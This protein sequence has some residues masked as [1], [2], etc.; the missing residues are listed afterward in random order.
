MVLLVPLRYMKA[1]FAYTISA[2]GD[3][4]V[5]IS[6]GNTINEVINK[7]VLQVFTSIQQ[8]TIPGVK[9][10]IPAYSSITV[11]YNTPYIIN[12]LKAGS[13]YTYIVN[14]LEEM[15]LT[16]VD[17]RVEE[18]NIVKIPACYDAAFAPDLQN[19]A[20]QKNMRVED[21]VAAHTN[22]VYRVYMLGFLPGFT[23]MGMVDESISMPR[24]ATPRTN[25]PAGSIGIAGTQ[26]G[27]YPFQSPGGW[28]IIAQTP[29]K[30]FDADR[31]VPVLLQ[32]GDHV[33]FYAVSQQEFNYIKT[34]QW[35]YA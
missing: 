14:L 32:A 35:A 28:N 1:P 30:L 17:N 26:T 9:D 10:I 11:V 27:I 4:A 31:L 34:T 25:V 29:L 18:N 24:L 6:F 12:Q 8:K 23:Y 15:L 7:Y 13:A 16:A 20:T 3:Q 19:I 33:Q 2:C 22:K 5:T 21:V